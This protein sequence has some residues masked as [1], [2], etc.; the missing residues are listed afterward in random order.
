[1]RDRDAYMAANLGGFTQIYPLA[2][3]N[4]RQIVY[5]NLINLEAELSGAVVKNQ[6]KTEKPQSETIIRR[7]T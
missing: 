4:P 1:M 7:N 5:E 2:T 6:K 3:D